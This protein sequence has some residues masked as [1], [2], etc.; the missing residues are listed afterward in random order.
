MT[1]KTDEQI[2]AEVGEFLAAWDNAEGCEVVEIGSVGPA[3]EQCNQI[4]VMEILREAMHRDMKR[5][6]IM[7]PALSFP[8]A[9]ETTNYLG[10]SDDQK[11]RAAT[12]AWRIWMVGPTDRVRA[13]KKD[14]KRIIMVQRAFPLCP[15]TGPVESIREWTEEVLRE[16]ADL[17]ATI[18]PAG[19]GLP[20]EEV[21]AQLA[22][23]SG[24]MSLVLKQ[25]LEALE[26]HDDNDEDDVGSG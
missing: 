10:A 3:V 14:G 11:T 8:Q 20:P 15:P 25:Y 19:R 13:A 17:R 22:Q 7:P 1:K 21:M 18:G 16:W 5:S 9:M 6:G 4:I 2:R 24:R 12:E 26:A 23:V